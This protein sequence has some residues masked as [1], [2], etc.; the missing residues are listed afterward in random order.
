MCELREGE[1][2]ERERE[3]TADR[4]TLPRNLNEFKLSKFHSNLV[5]SKSDLIELQ[6]FGLK[7]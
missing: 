3:D 6:K 4:W 2:R 5:R 1:R 7:Y